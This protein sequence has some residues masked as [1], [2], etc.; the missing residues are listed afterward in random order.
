MLDAAGLPAGSRVL[1]VGAGTGPLVVA[2]AERGLEVVGVDNA[3]LTTTYLRGRL[4]DH[5]RASADLADANALPYE[6]P[7]ADDFLLEFA[8]FVVTTPMYRAMS[9][10]ERAQLD[11]AL[12]DGVRRIESGQD[13]RPAFEANVAWASA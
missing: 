3:P 4:A 9:P 13:P 1:D 10:L 6:L 2:A 11:S 8:P 7:P 12:A 5:P